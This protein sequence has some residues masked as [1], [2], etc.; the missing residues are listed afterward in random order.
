MSTI[1][2]KY[3]IIQRKN[4]D[5]H[6]FSSSSQCMFSPQQTATSWKWLTLPWHRFQIFT[7]QSKTEMCVPLYSTTNKTLRE[8][9]QH[10]SKF[11]HRTAPMSFKIGWEVPLVF[12]NRFIRTVCCKELNQTRSQFVPTHKNSHL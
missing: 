5:N 11:Y 4:V 3:N 9:E 8:P 6:S 2:K 12:A 1:N 10:R 7:N